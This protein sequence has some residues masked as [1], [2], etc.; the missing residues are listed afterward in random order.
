MDA[1]AVARLELAQQLVGAG[2][3]LR[4]ARR[5]VG[6][7][8]LARHLIVVVAVARQAIEI[9]GSL[10]EGGVETGL[11]A[12]GGALAAEAARPLVAADVAQGET[13]QETRIEAIVG[14][15]REA[16]GIVGQ[17]AGIGVAGNAAGA[18]Q[19]GAPQAP[20]GG[21]LAITGL[22]GSRLAGPG[23]RDAGAAGDAAA[24]EAHLLAHHVHEQQPAGQVGG[25][26]ARVVLATERSESGL[27]LSQ[28]VGGHGAD[29]G[30]EVAARS[31]DALVEGAADGR[32]V[33]RGAADAE[34]AGLEGE[35]DVV[36]VVGERGLEEGIEAAGAGI[37][38]GD[39]AR[40]I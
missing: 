31:G 38:A 18:A 10:C 14:A 27:A 1:D 12:A 33:G 20:R 24:G 17:G 19:C 32:L 34:A 23:D 39:A 21:G 40:G 13:G 35:I 25:A 29:H 3:A 8:D 36:G 22:G 15:G 16:A 6:Q 4:E 30:G 37:G 2:A 11:V 26:E 28:G 9:E 5:Q 7:H